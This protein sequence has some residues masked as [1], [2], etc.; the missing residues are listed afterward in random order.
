MGQ[1]GVEDRAT[2]FAG[3]VM[4][5]D[6]PFPSDEF[7]FGRLRM[8]NEF[9]EELNTGRRIIING[10]PVPQEKLTPEYFDV[11]WYVLKDQ[12]NS[13]HIDGT[14][15]PKDA[16][17]VVTKRFDGDADAIAAVKNGWFYIGVDTDE[18]KT[19][20]GYQEQYQLNLQPWSESNPTGYRMIDASGQYV[21]LLEGLQPLESYWVAE[22][23]D[24]APDPYASS[25]SWRV[26]NTE[27]T[28]ISGTDA[29]VRV[30]Q[31]RAYADDVTLDSLHPERA[32]SLQLL[33]LHHLQ[34]GLQG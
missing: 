17:L 4:R 28:E 8:W 24:T 22:H 12:Q 19:N 3:F 30:A 33:Q 10:E 25:R 32:A 15:L 31:V 7:I 11:R 1:Y 6:L 13:W 18:S 16:K 20:G 2:T 9:Q 14:L 26:Y 29:R 27:Q 23:N 5:L 34:A 21:W